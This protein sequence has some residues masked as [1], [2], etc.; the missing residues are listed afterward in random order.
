MV[1]RGLRTVDPDWICVVDEEGEGL[2]GLDSC[3]NEGGEEA[4]GE[5]VAWVCKG[6]LG[7]GVVL[8]EGLV[9]GWWLGSGG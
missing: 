7:H 4:V 8:K 5:W 2:V 9:C 6:G 3:R 1:K